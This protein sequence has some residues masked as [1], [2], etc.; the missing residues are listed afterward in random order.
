MQSADLFDLLTR[1]GA[2]TA[3]A[4]LLIWLIDRMFRAKLSAKPAISQI[5]TN[6]DLK[7]LIESAANTSLATLSLLQE[8]AKSGIVQ[9]RILDRLEM[10]A[11]NI[12]NEV[13]E[14]TRK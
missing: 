5:I 7:R 10:Q 2:P 6:D 12:Y 14:I 9:T 8:L 4:G 13:R 3:I 1:F 11:M